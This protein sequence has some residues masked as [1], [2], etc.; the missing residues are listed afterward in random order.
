MKANT[1]GALLL[2]GSLGLAGCADRNLEVRTVRA[3][4]GTRG[5]RVTE[6]LFWENEGG[7][8]R[9]AD[10][11]YAN[12]VHVRVVGTIDGK[13]FNAYIVG[14]PNKTISVLPDGTDIGRYFSSD[15]SQAQGSH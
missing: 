8:Y 1:L 4:T 12:G 11:I 9:Q 3:F 14:S 5:E 7:R 10:I 6:S 13:P 15:T 2:A